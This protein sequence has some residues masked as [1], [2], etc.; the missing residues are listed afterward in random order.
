MPLISLRNIS[1]AFGGPPLLDSIQMSIEPGE[2]ICLVGRNGEGKST[3]LKLILGELE[4]DEGEFERLPSL[5]IARLDQDPREDI[6]GTIFDVV[7]QGAG[8][9][10]ALISEY[11]HITGELGGDRDT[12]ILDR[13]HDI[14]ETLQRTGGWDLDQKL[15]QILTRLSLNGDAEFNALSGGM[16]RRTLLAQALV[17]DPDLLLLD[18]PTNHLDIDSIRWLE[19]FMLKYEKAILFITHD[20]IFLRKLAT[21]II[22]LDRGQL[23]SW[24]CSYDRFLQ[25]KAALLE[26]EEKQNQVFDKKLSKEEIWIRKGIQARR[27]R[28]E[29]RVRALKSLRI[30][31]SQRRERS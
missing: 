4:P 17:S 15:E 22:E 8:P 2:R 9:A 20:R 23:S 19:D 5:K 28:N 24:E 14:Q 13:M 26:A 18:E 6:S 1:L 31:R 30:E 7:S 21:R 27:T 16:K 3:L 11:H 29:G 12:D 10:A 25:R